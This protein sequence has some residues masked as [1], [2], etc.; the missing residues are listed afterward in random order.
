MLNHRARSARTT[1]A[2]VRRRR[3]GRGSR[4][5]CALDF[6]LSVPE[7][8]GFMAAARAL[9]QTRG[10]LTLRSSLSF[11]PFPTPPSQSHAQLNSA[12]DCQG[13]MLYAWFDG[14]GAL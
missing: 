9:M 10:R 3:R 7:K 1:T 2:G 5:L 13:R 12:C 6:A 4:E 11:A 8:Y 14:R